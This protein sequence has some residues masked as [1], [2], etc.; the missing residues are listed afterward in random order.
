LI[1]RKIPTVVEA[2]NSTLTVLFFIP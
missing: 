1:R 2:Q